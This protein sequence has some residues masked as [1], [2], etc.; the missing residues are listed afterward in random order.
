MKTPVTQ[1]LVDLENVP[2][3]LSA[4]EK[5]VD[6]NTIV[7]VFHNKTHEKRV[8]AIKA[9]LEAKNV[10][11]KFLKLEKTGDNALD[12]HMTFFLGWELRANPK[13]KF[14]VFTNDSGFD[15]LIDRLRKSK[16]DVTR[17]KIPRPSKKKKAANKAVSKNNAKQ[18]PP[19][20][21][22]KQASSASKSKPASKTSKKPKS[23]EKAAVTAKKS[24]PTKP[25]PAPAT[26]L[27][28][29]ARD[30]FDKHN[31]KPRPRTLSSLRNDIKQHLQK[32]KLT[33]AM[34]DQIVAHLRSLGLSPRSEAK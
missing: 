15:S 18:T 21:A 26:N 31:T 5:T 19:T 11:V 25:V 6:G 14:L 2:H 22:K 24:P 3:A 28:Q 34:V 10:T 17:V 29:L 1:I 30:Y 27:E 23:T 33:E 8:E 20:T 9:D 12:F 4:L 13:G 32:H 7:F 16:K